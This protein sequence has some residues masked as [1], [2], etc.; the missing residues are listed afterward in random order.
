MLP[1]R[2]NP[3]TERVYFI[4]TESGPG[5]VRWYATNVRSEIAAAREAGLEVTA[6]PTRPA[7]QPSTQ[8]PTQQFLL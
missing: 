6:H 8:Q 4:R 2:P 7:T 3:Y 5:L 1:F